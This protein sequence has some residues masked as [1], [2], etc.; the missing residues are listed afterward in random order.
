MDIG[1]SGSVL[2][3]GYYGFHNSG[4]EA[5]L[6]AVTESIKPICGPE[7]I[8]IL[9]HDP[10]ETSKKIGCRSVY[11]FSPVKVLRAIMRCKIL[12]FGGGSL[13]QDRTSTRSLLYYLF[14]L[15]TAKLL[16]KKVMVFANGIGPVVDAKNRRR[17]RKALEKVDLISLRDNKS[18]E[19]LRDMGLERADII[20][21]ADPVFGVKRPPEELGREILKIAGVPEGKYML[22]ST[23]SWGDD[24]KFI[25]DMAEL[26]DRVYSRFGLNIV[27]A[28]LHI[29]YD[30]E[31][32]RE[33]QGHMN[34]RSYI[35]DESMDA[36]SHMSLCAGAELV[37]AVRL[38]ALIFASRVGTP[39]AGISYDPKIN[40]FVNSLGLPLA[41]DIE[42]FEPDKAF[43]VIS[44][45]LENREKYVE[46]LKR[47]VSEMEKAAAENA[48]LFKR[49]ITQQ[50]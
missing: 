9:S 16:N 36:D 23:R 33:I 2:L 40:E 5:I 1:Y 21:T 30:A 41:G 38:H 19:E 25:T 6:Q 50:E 29:P 14:I 27:F 24:S 22:V 45:I 11:C 20:I 18:A 12:V 28:P 37:L 34:E 39:V 32:S 48:E 42:R 46:K 44:E 49:L 17:V 47:S 10:D 15:R 4:D 31:Q 7:A 3:S 26:C 8:T 13:L 43:A 35:L